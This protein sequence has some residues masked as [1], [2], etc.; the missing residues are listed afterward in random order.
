MVD[1]RSPIGVFDSG[2]GGISVLRE[3]KKLMPHED[4]IFIGDSANAPYGMKT[5]QE[6]IELSEHSLLRLLSMGAKQI[7]IACNTATAVAADALREK[8]R[9]IEIVGIEPAIKPAAHDNR[10]GRIAVLAT[11]LTVHQ[12]RI[13]KLYRQCSH[14]AHIELVSC[15]GLV[16]LIES[17][18]T[19]DE[20]LF[21]YLSEKLS[22]YRDFDAYV[23]GCTHYPLIRSAFLRVLGDVPLY[24]GGEGTARRSRE[25]LSRDG[26]LNSSDREGQIE[27]IN[28]SNDENMVSL[29]YSFMIE[30]RN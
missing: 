24:D 12:K 4:F 11:D 10:G 27:I 30:D 21:S 19:Y 17:G 28:T 16:E 22:L 5:P 2:V 3:L 8:Y 7:V 20:E 9:D 13:E 15:P 23:L 25:L 26:L 18:H 6:V 14:E 29:S 1:K